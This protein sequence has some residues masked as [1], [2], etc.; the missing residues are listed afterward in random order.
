MAP[1]VAQST[2]KKMM[3]FSCNKQKKV[4]KD[5]II[6]TTVQP[7]D[8]FFKKG[9]KSHTHAI[10]FLEN[11]FIQHYRES[12]GTSTTILKSQSA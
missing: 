1:L 6:L 7:V 9:H 11:I 8:T 2:G 4:E 10:Q 12:R 5:I 3:L